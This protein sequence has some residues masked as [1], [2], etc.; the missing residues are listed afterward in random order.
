MAKFPDAVITAMHHAASTVTCLPVEMDN[1]EWK[2]AIFFV[3]PESVSREKIN[4]I[5]KQSCLF[6]VGLD[7]DLKEPAG[8]TLILLGVDIDIGLPDLLRGEIL[9]LPGHLQSHFETVKR[10]SEQN[11]IDL[12]IGDTFC[13]LLHQQSIPLQDEHRAVFAELIKEAS[14]R[15]ALLRMR[16][17]YDPEAAFAELASGGHYAQ[18]PETTREGADKPEHH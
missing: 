11:S 5:A 7:A 3:L 18:P 1:A 2:S 14:S 17:Q 12:F 13:N 10:I 6:P 8:A 4:S 9:F 15:D 16:S